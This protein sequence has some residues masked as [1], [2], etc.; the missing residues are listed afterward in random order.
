MRKTATT[1]RCVPRYG[2][3]STEVRTIDLD[4]APGADEP[5]L[6]ERVRFWFAVRGI[7]DALYDLDVDDNGFFAIIND[8]AYAQSWGTSV[9]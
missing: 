4:V 3:D 7:A 1:M 9:L 5:E 6:R 2:Y 8:E